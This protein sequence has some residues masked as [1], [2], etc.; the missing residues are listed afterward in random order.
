MSTNNPYKSTNIETIYELA[1]LDFLFPLTV[2][3]DLHRYIPFLGFSNFV[4]MGDPE[5]GEEEQ[6]WFSRCMVSTSSNPEIATSPETLLNE[7]EMYKAPH[8][9][10]MEWTRCPNTVISFLE[11]MHLTSRG[12]RLVRIIM[13]TE[14]NDGSSYEEYS[15]V[16]LQ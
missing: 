1:I 4:R 9:G 13:P 7:V 15:E 11:K 5:E 16:H 8:F 10:E 12:Y 6:L 14:E 2:T 3:K